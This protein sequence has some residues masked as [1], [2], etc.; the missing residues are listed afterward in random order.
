MALVVELHAH[1]PTHTHPTRTQ[2]RT[3]QPAREENSLLGQECQWH[4]K[5]PSCV[6]N[7]GFGT[8][9]TSP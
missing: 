4:M 5:A 3:L 1:T 7:F 6:C 9:F 2:A 8:N